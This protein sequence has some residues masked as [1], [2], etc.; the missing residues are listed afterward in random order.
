MEEEF[1]HADWWD[2][3]QFYDSTVNW[4]GKVD[5]LQELSQTGKYF[6]VQSGTLMPSNPTQADET[7]IRDVMLYCFTSYLLGV[8][9]NNTTFG[10]G[11]A[12]S[13]D[14]ASGYYTEM[15]API[16]TPLNNYYPTQSVYA[17]DFT[18]GKVI[19]NPTT[20]S[21]TINLG[22]TY[23]TLTGQTITTLTLNSHTGTILL[24]P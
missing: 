8:N 4:Q 20:T 12:T 3:N 2:S 22:A 7:V 24:N 19:V 17:R 14:G 6:I 23:K 10:F 18:N 5:N 11:S 1:V 15:G 9:G 21:A 16:G 13:S